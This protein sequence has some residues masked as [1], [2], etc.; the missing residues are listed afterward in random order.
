[1]T[2]LF[3]KLVA[4]GGIVYSMYITGRVKNKKMVKGNVSLK[5]FLLFAYAVL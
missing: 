3:D 5:A 1:M 4:K 2:R